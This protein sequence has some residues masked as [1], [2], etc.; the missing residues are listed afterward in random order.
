M[1]KIGIAAL[2]VALGGCV[3]TGA[4]H[5]QPNSS[6]V[7]LD[8]EPSAVRGCD[9]LGSIRANSMLTGVLSS[10]GY[11]SLIAD[12][13]NKAAAKGGNHVLVF[14]FTSNYGSNNASGDVYR[15]RQ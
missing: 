4:A 9:N 3:T 6:R 1:E 13:K 15:C 14:D 12:L 2:C 10:Q 8:R 7:Q 11:D 5:P